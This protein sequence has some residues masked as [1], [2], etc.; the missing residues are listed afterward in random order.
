MRLNKIIPLS[1][2]IILICLIGTVSAAENGND[3]AVLSI[4]EDSLEIDRTL[5]EYEPVL[6]E[7]ENKLKLV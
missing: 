6:S 4:E 3:T 5:N 1:I 7:S 2:F